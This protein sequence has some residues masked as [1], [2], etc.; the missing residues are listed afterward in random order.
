MMM[1]MV[2]MLLVVIE[3]LVHVKVLLLFEAKKKF[4]LKLFHRK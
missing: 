1:V 4:G 3:L 2:V